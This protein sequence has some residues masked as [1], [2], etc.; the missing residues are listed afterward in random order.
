MNTYLNSA[1]RATA[2]ITMAT[3]TL[4]ATT[5]CSPEVKS[6]SVVK[7]NFKPAHD[8]TVQGSCI[9]YSKVGNS[10]ICTVYNYYTTH[11]GDKWS[12]TLENDQGD[13]STWGISK[14]LYSDVKVGQHLS[15]DGK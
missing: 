3:A 2:T 9:V 8:E 1:L 10:Q 5:A 15:L 7:K 6:G 11:I 14:E 13:R 12:V 4:L